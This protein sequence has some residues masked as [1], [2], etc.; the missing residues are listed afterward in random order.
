MMDTTLQASIKF[1]KYK[2]LNV[3]KAGDSSNSFYYVISNYDY[4]SSLLHYTPA[5]HQG[6]VALVSTVETKE[7]CQRNVIDLTL[8]DNENVDSVS[9]LFYLLYQNKI[10]T[11]QAMAIVHLAYDLVNIWKNIL[12]SKIGCLP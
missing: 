10:I 2:T 4:L 9:H 7:S 12:C 3:F 1:Q 6:I 11:S 8:T 5:N